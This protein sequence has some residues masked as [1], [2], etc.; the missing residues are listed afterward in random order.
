MPSPLNP[1]WGTFEEYNIYSSFY[2]E[3]VTALQNKKAVTINR[4]LKSLP[5][6]EI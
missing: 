5:H 2:N 1:P 6:G 3:I 4:V